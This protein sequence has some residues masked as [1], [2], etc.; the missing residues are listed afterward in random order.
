MDCVNSACV[1]VFTVFC[2]FHILGSHYLC[3]GKAIVLAHGPSLLPNHSKLFIMYI[4]MV[5][6]AIVDHDLST[7]TSVD[8]QYNGMPINIY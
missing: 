7:S 1:E 4:V 3:P 6:L 2:N 5:L 8:G